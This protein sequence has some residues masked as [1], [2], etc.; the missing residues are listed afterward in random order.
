MPI[1]RYFVG[2]EVTISAEIGWERLRN[3]ELLPAAEAQ[4]YEVLLTTDKNIRYQQNLK[5]RLIA[6]I[7]I[8]HAQ[9]PALKPTFSA[10][11]MP[12]I[13]LRLAAISKSKSLTGS[14][15]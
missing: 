13:R 3:G 15:F 7:V 11:S 4:G 9:W 1:R 12:S 14:E 10:L 2:H 6:I 8:G 5:D